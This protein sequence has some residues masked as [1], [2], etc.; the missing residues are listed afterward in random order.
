MCQEI[1]RKFLVCGDFQKTAFKSMRIM[2]GYLSSVPERT[3]RVR[4]MGDKAFI[5]IKGPSNATG[6]ARF[7]WEREILLDEARQLLEIC[8]PGIIDKT[9]F[10]VENTDGRHVW[11]VDV[12]HGE[13]EGLVMA[14]IELDDENESFNKPDW[15]GK[16]VTGDPKYFNSML[17]RNP[18]S[19]W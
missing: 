7:E 14:E 12:F 13:N 10:F 3:V 16:E 17:M 1:E 5:T 19:K 8:E 18:Y 6:V 15:I 11:E 9:R 2:Q 4:L